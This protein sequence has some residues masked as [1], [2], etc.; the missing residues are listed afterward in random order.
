M[1]TTHGEGQIQHEARAPSG[2]WPRDSCVAPGQNTPAPYSSA[3]PSIGVTTE[4]VRNANVTPQT[5]HRDHT[6]ITCTGIGHTDITYV[7]V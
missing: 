1:L 7:C 6:H 4:L 3:A 5:P 2:W